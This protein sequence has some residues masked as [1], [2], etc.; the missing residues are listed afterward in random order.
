MPSR[1]GGFPPYV[2][3]KKRK[4]DNQALIEDLIEKGYELC[5]VRVIGN[6]RHLA[7]SFW[8][9]SW[10]RHLNSFSD[11]EN[12]LPRGRSYVRQGAILDL[13]IEGGSISALVSGSEIYK[14][15]IK[16]DTL[17][18]KTWVAIQKKC[19]GQIES[20]LE[21]LQGQLSAEVM[22]QVA[23]KNDGLF[24]SPKEISLSCSCPDWAEMCKHVAAV[25][26]GV[27]VRLDDEPELLFLLRGVNAQDL[28]AANLGLGEEVAAGDDALDS[29]DLAGIFGIE[30]D[31]DFESVE[32]EGPVEVAGQDPPEKKQDRYNILGI[33]DLSSAEISHFS[34]FEPTGAEICQLRSDFGFTVDEFCGL[35]EVSKATVY[36]WEK[37][38]GA[39]KVQEKPKNRLRYMTEI[40]HEVLGNNS[41]A[42]SG[43]NK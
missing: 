10:C 5:P 25:L 26:Y 42:K 12:R 43:Q 40:R 16:I 35:L 30:I 1:W 17:N 36:R 6:K 34:D 29:G 37:I 15:E 7:N 8:G 2:S 19:S 41:V 23:D 18:S 24:P 32:N 28:I 4:Q 31:G 38:I 21:L 22:K 13:G 27:G 39:V 20:L 11:Y 9:Q 3:L 33:Q 14:V